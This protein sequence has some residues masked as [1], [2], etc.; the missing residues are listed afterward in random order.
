MKLN[1]MQLKQ[2]LNQV[3]AQVLVPGLHAEASVAVDPRAARLGVVEPGP[4]DVDEH[5]PLNGVPDVQRVL[6]IEQD[7]SITAVRLVMVCPKRAQS[8]PASQ[9]VAPP[10]TASRY[11]ANSPRSIA[12]RAWRVSSRM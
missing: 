2:T 9:G 12:A 10:S 7:E 3:D 5:H 1:A 6:G 8:A 4:A 11:A